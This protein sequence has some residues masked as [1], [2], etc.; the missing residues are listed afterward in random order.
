MGELADRTTARIGDNRKSR[1]VPIAMRFL[2]VTA[3]SP[4]QPSSSS[5][6][7]SVIQGEPYLNPNSPFCNWSADESR[8]HRAHRLREKSDAL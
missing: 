5:K 6:R 2:A 4:T 7:K 1:S 3:A 8:K